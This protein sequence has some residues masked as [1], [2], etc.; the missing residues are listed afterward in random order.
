MT[1]LVGR[2]ISVDHVCY[3]LIPN[4]EVRVREV[5]FDSYGIRVEY[6]VTP[7]LPNIDPEVLEPVP[8]DPNVPDPPRLNF[9]A[10]AM[11]NLFNV[12]TYADGAFGLSDD[13]Q[14]TNGVVTLVP[15]LPSEAYWLTITLGPWTAPERLAGACAMTILL[16]GRTE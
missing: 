12:Y 13:G 4:R 15:L 8:G 16:G 6:T 2:H 14:R 9:L 1:P 5:W 3:D 11:D 10:H 7:A